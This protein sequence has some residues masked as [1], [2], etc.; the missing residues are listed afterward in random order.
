MNKLVFSTLLM[1]VFFGSCSKDDDCHCV[2][3]DDLISPE[4]AEMSVSTGTSTTS[5]TGVLMV[6]PCTGDSSLY[7]GNYGINGTLS[8]INATYTIKDGSI[9]KATAPVRLPLGDYNFLY[10]GLSKNS[11]TDSIYDAAAI[12]EPGL[13]VGADLSDLY[14]TMYQDNYKDTT[15]MPVYDYL[16]A[17]NPIKVGTDKMQAT[18]KH[19]TAG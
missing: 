6:Y 13:R 19:A 7:Y 12:R 8:P 4:L 2:N 3:T 1:G 18:M 11:Q 5:F 10:W 14:M 17:V 15:Y 9:Y 16:H